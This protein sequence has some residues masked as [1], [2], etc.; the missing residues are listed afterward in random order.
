MT[1]R[2]GPRR[3]GEETQST[4]KENRRIGAIT[5]DSLSLSFGLT[6]PSW[7]RQSP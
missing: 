7:V 1:R 4:A 5:H 3:K 6:D 2:S